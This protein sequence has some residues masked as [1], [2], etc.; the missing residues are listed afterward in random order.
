MPF[1]TADLCDDHSDHLQI[2]EPGR[3]RHFG[4]KPRFFGPIATVQAPEDNSH[5]RRRLEEP[6]DGRVLVVDGGASRRCAL[7]GDVLGDLA[8]KNGWAGLVINGHV[9]DSV[10][11]ATLDLGVLALGTYP[12]K[13]VKRG[14]G[15]N[16]IPVAFAGV[17]F[18]VGHVLYADEDGLIVSETTLELPA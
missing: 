17:L 3:L 2:A 5:V 7:L 9:R 6:G 8:V 4:G 11:L 1:K 13:S 15:Q 16:D 18:E 12:V 14:F 10:D